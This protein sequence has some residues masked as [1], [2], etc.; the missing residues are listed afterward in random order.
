MMKK[1]LLVLVSLAMLFEMGINAFALDVEVENPSY[2][3]RF[4]GQKISINVYHWGEYI[5]D[6]S[7]EDTLLSLIHI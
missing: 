5:S 2:Y 1:I 3:Q 6:G 4:Q 7:E